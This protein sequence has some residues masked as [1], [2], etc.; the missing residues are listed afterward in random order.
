MAKKSKG[1][2]RG[3]QAQ[4]GEMSDHGVQTSPDKSKGRGI[5]SS[6]ALAVGEVM[7][8]AAKL[9]G[10]QSDFLGTPS[11]VISIEKMTSLVQGK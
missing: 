4:T 1:K 6:F 8:Q 10:S 9:K 3:T 5:G 11:E 7:E 2:S